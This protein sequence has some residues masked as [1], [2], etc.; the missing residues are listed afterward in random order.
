LSTPRPACGRAF[1]LALALAAGCAGDDGAQAHASLHGTV[2]DSDSGKRLSGVHVE[3]ESDT[4]EHAADTTDK[5]GSYALNVVSS[6]PTGR[7][8]ARKAGYETRVVSV[9]LDDAAVGLDLTLAP[10]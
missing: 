4:L 10:Q 8:T 2:R 3:F 5:D 1:A 9:F 7:L 6:A